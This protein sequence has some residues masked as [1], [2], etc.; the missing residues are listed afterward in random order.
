MFFIVRV[1]PGRERAAA[2][3]IMYKA[4]AEGYDILSILVPEDLKG[5]IY[6]EAKNAYSVDL[7]CQDVKDVRGRIQGI[8]KE[9]EVSKYFVETPTIEALSVGDLVEIKTGVFKHMK[10]R[11]I[12][13][14][15]SKNE[16]TIEL[17]EGGSVF[18]I[19]LSADMVKLIEKGRK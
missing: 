12:E 3:V 11:V 19:T 14:D 9:D 2:E 1:T 6:V 7:A 15:R 8:M 13:V 16:V 5:F 10:A 18:P 17:Q 4:L